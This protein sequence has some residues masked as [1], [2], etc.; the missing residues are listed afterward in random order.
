[1]TTTM[2]APVRVRLTDE[3]QRA[4][5]L[6]LAERIAERDGL[7]RQKKAD[8]KE[9]QELIDEVDEAI[10]ELAQEIRDGEED[11]AQGD[12]FVDQKALANVAAHAGESLG[13]EENGDEA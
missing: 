4:K 6:R 3:E 1:M 11:R 10:S 5:G 8:A 2:N 7:V 13:N 12:L 9:A